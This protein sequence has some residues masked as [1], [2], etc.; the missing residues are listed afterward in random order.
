MLDLRKAFDLVDHSTLLHKL[1]LYGMSKECNQWLKS[2]LSHRS[3]QVSYNGCL[4]DPLPIS[5]GVPQGSILG[6]LLFILYMN[7][8]ILE[9]EN[10]NLDMFADDSTLY[11]AEESVQSISLQ[12]EQQLLPITNWIS[13]N[14]M[15]L[16]VEKLFIEIMDLQLS[17]GINKKC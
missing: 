1:S 6:P 13:A 2:Y 16:N 15:V 11:V 12:L 8:L 9:I 14:R 4:S 7:D 10:T 3:Q 5:A 17:F